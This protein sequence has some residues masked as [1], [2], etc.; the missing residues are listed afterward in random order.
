MNR[1][2]HSGGFVIPDDVK[3]LASSVLVHRV[4]HKAESRLLGNAVENTLRDILNSVP[5][6]V[7]EEEEVV[8]EER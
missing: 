6:P 7:E 8:G 4:I 2:P 3:Y 1:L 5:V